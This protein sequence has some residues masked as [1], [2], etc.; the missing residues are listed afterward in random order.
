MPSGLPLLDGLGPEDAPGFVWIPGG[1]RRPAARALVPACGEVQER[2]DL[3]S[4]STVL[5]YL[6]RRAAAQIGE[7]LHA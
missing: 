3:E 7:M 1:R 2:I 6:S 4:A 5:I